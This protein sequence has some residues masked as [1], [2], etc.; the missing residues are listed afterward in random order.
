VANEI[1]RIE[2]PRV[3]VS[4]SLISETRVPDG[5]V[6]VVLEASQALEEHKSLSIWLFSNVTSMLVELG[7]IMVSL[8][9]RL[10]IS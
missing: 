4:V 8:G 6:R 1:L 9:G 2:G 5:C 7:W 3:S 10:R